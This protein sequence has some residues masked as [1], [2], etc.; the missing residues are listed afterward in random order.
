MKKYFY[1][2]VW[3]GLLA[4]ICGGTAYAQGTLSGAVT[5]SQGEGLIGAS[6][7]IKSTSSG[8][9]TDFDGNYTV[10]VPTGDQTIV[11]SYT[12]YASQEFQLS[13]Q[14]G[15]TYTRDLVLQTDNLQLDEVVVT[16]SFTGRT[17]KTSPM[18]ITLLNSKQLQRL[19]SNSQADILRTVPGITAEG[20]GGEVA[21]NVFVRGLPSGG[22]YQFTPLQVDGLP[23]L[24]TFGLNSSAHDVY[25]RNDIGIR[26]LE[27]TRGGSSTLFGAGSVAG[28]I[29]YTSIT[30]TAT[31]QNTVQLEWGQGGRAKVDVLSSGPLAEN[32]FYSVSGFYRYDAGPLETGLATRGHQIRANIKR[33]FNDGK[34]S[35]TVYAQSIDDNVQFYLPYPLANNTGQRERPVGNDGETVFTTLTGAATDFAFDTPNGRFESPIEDGVSTKGGYLMAS[36]KHSFDNDLNLSIKA[37]AANYD[38]NFNLFLDGDG[39]RNVPESAGV[40]LSNRE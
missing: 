9:V 20:G 25:F 32:L 18:S 31:P 37:K 12:G 36:L 13:V 15:Q 5:D 26:N 4:L 22:Q 14:D 10:S 28:I 30:G 19:S 39:V 21:S 40:Y 2:L 7:L 17:Q 16:G 23:V 8:T 33:L 29:N 34:S 3:V 35:F 11:V 27:F 1:S 24:S 38:H 6:I